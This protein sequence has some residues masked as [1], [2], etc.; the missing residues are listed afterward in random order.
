MAPSARRGTVAAIL[1]PIASREVSAVDGNTVTTRAGRISARLRRLP[2]F[3]S[4]Y[5]AVSWALFLPA[6]E[7]RGGTYAIDEDR[8][9]VFLFHIPDLTRQP[10]KALAS[11]IPAPWLNHDLRQMIYVTALLLLFGV[12]LERLEGTTRV[13]GIFFGS[14]LAGA[15]VAGLLLHGLYPRWW[16]SAFARHAWERTWSG[17]SAGA[18]GIAGAF[19][20]RAR[21]PWLFLSFLVLWE[22]NLAIWFL[23]QYTPAFHLTA[24]L[25]GFVVTRYMLRPRQSVADHPLASDKPTNSS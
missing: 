2:L 8:V 4:V 15:L 22:V 6:A 19:V 20:A 7:R 11:L 9:D 16:D 5:L 3:V 23:H 17:G 21:R 24:L 1:G 14:T 18:F 13:A 25:T 10:L 12:L